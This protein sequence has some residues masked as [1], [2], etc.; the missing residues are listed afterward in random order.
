MFQQV[1]TKDDP[2]TKYT[3][4]VTGRIF[5][6]LSVKDTT[7]ANVGHFKVV[8]TLLTILNNFIKEIVL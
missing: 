8:K 7:F 6:F 3:I 1:N 2:R 5:P 4:P